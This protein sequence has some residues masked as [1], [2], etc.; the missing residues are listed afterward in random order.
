MIEKAC[1]RENS[2]VQ[3][4]SSGLW[5]EELRV[6]VSKCEKCAEVE[7]VCWWMS[8]IAGSWSDS[9][10]LPD[11]DRIWL[12]AQRAEQRRLRERALRPAIIAQEAV[13]VCLLLLLFARLVLKWPIIE[14]GIAGFLTSVPN[15]L[16]SFSV[17]VIG[18]LMPYLKSP[19]LI[20][21]CLAFGYFFLLP[22]LR[23]AFR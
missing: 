19:V 8:D 22:R 10:P 11:P 16:V 6:H 3:A 7:K 13:T 15:T 23:R 21:C 2:V 18:R 12:R 17:P 9:E 14:K 4:A 5:S 1:P 20:C